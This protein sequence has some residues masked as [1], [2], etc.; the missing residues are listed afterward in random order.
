M[1]PKKHSR[2]YFETLYYVN[3]TG[4]GFD[5]IVLVQHEEA[6]NCIACFNQ[7]SFPHP[8]RS[9]LDLCL[10]TCMLIFRMVISPSLNNIPSL[11]LSELATIS[12]THSTL[13]KAHVNAALNKVT[14]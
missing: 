3:M 11:S 6:S 12:L 14:S 8:I 10:T 5:I 13:K 4:Y 2:L 1:P 9:I 7:V